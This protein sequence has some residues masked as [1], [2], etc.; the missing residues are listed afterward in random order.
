MCVVVYY[1]SQRL[2]DWEVQSLYAIK[3][4]GIRMTK[5]FDMMGIEVTKH[6][7]ICRQVKKRALYYQKFNRASNNYEKGNNKGR[8]D[9]W[10]SLIM[11]VRSTCWT[12]QRCKREFPCQWEMFANMDTNTMHVDTKVLSK[13]RKKTKNRLQCFDWFVRVLG[14]LG[15]IPRETIQHFRT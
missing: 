15:I 10:L 5:P 2:S 7:D 13:Q 14:C 1:L 6:K 4:K 8:S 3:I 9:D 11:K 12:I